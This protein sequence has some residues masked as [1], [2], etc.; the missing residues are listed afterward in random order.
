MGQLAKYFILLPLFHL[1]AAFALFLYF[2][3]L[4]LLTFIIHQTSVK[5]V[6][7]TTTSKGALTRYSYLYQSISVS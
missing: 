7:S 2:I 3:G 1:C 5:K 4:T 6:T